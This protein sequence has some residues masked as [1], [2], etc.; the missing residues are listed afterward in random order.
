[1]SEDQ[2]KI[3]KIIVPLTCH[4]LEG[5]EI[6]G[7]IFLDFTSSLEYGLEEL[8]DFFH[9]P[10][11]F[12]PLRPNGAMKPLLIARHSI[13]RVDVPQLT[14]SYRQTLESVLAQKKTARV[15][16]HGSASITATVFVNLPEEYSRILDLLNQ[17]SSFFPAL[18]DDSLS[19]LNSHHIYRIE[20][21]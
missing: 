6:E 19:L 4:M 20:E 17:K 1:M 3:P 14:D 10:A 2:F 18:I 7:E 12:F 15:F 16:M 9:L 8:I 11:P 13:T 21:I 5:E